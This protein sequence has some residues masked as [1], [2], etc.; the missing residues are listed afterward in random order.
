M[1]NGVRSL[2]LHCSNLNA[3]NL[4][5][6]FIEPFRPIVD[7]IV[8]QNIKEPILNT[9]S[10][11]QLASIFSYYVH[12]NGLKHTVQ[13]AIVETIDSFKRAV[14]SNDAGEL[15]LPEVIPLEQWTGEE[16]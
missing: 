10:K 9:E 16:K 13:S 15:H 8:V 1:S 7:L 6:D 12:M 14:L 5:D 11:K 2:F 4:A 3:F